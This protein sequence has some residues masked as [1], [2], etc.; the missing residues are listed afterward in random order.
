MKKLLIIT[1]MFILV[2]VSK[3]SS[4]DISHV[5]RVLN[6]LAQA[7]F[8]PDIDI[9]VIAPSAA[10]LKDAPAKDICVIKQCDL[11]SHN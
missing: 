5:Q 1:L 9:P 10:I 11:K 4:K 3:S 6:S 2:A 8:S 7:D